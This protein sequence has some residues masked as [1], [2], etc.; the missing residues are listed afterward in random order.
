MRRGGFDHHDWKHSVILSPH[1]NWSLGRLGTRRRRDGEE[2]IITI[3][4]EQRAEGEDRGAMPD[5]G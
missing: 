1:K 5:R 2:Q 4:R 3:L